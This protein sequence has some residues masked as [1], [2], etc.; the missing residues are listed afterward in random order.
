[1]QSFGYS[2]RQ[3]IPVDFEFHQIDSFFDLFFE[4]AEF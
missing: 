2:L 4:E 1:M 3:N